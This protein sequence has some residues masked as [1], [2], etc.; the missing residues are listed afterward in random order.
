M[1]G[2]ADSIRVAADRTTLSKPAATTE[3][4]PDMDLTEA[5]MKRLAAKIAQM[6]ELRVGRSCRGLAH[7]RH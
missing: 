1:H 4:T 6:E 7:R 5:T 2:F 3:Q